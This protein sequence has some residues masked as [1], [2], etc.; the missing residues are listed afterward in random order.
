[1]TIP[2]HIHGPPEPE[3]PNVILLGSMYAL[4]HDE[5]YLDQLQILAD[6][7]N[8]EAQEEIKHHIFTRHY[9]EC[10]NQTLND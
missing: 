10:G 1:M 5:I 9:D 7:G 6:S 3:K 4:T 2:S 8:T